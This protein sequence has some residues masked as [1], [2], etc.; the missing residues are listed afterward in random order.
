MKTNEVGRKLI[1]SFEG[2]RLTAYICPAGIW[3][4]GY[5]HTHNVQEGSV[6][7]E[8]EAENLLVKDLQETESVVAN[9]VTV[10]LNENEFSA[11]VSFVFN[12]GSGN[13]SEST[14]L[15]M[16]NDGDRQG[17]AD[18][19]LRWDKAGGEKLPGLTRRRILE[20]RLFLS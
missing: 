12:V 10:E 15:K 4:I 6:V 7:N 20:R 11:L 14:L 18:Q 9:L 5:G 3:T 1:K 16:L 2:L 13:F 19:F 8:S 17:A